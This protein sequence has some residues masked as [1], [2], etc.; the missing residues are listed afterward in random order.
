MTLPRRGRP[1]KNAWFNPRAAQLRLAELERSFDALIAE[2]ELLQMIL[3]NGSVSKDV[4]T[5]FVRNPGA[6]KPK[7]RRWRKRNLTTQIVAF[8]EGKKGQSFLP[9]QI[10]DG[11]GLPA[12]RRKTLASLLYVLAKGKRVKK[13]AKGKGYGSVG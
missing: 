8:L 7:G 10:G 1:P 9:R 3:G 6:A 5:P 2:R 11:L 4:P 13:L 12:S